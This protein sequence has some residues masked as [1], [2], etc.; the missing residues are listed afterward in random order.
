MDRYVCQGCGNIC[1][2]PTNI[3]QKIWVRTSRGLKLHSQGKVSI[4]QCPQCQN[5]TRVP[6]RP[7]DAPLTHL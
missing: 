4:D 6:L 2:R 7:L 5:G 1:S 3:M